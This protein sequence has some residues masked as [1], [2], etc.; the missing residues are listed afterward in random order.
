MSTAALPT[1]PS[2]RALARLVLQ[3]ALPRP[4]KAVLHALL[5][6]ARADLTVYHSQGQLAWECD[7][8]RPIIKKALATLKAQAILRVR[9]GPRQHYATEYRLDLSRL[10]SRA[11]Y[12]S[13][14]STDDDVPR[15]GVGSLG[16]REI[17]LPA[18][19]AFLALQGATQLPPEGATAPAQHENQLPSDNAEGHSVTPSGQM[20]FPQ[21][22]QQEQEKKVFVHTELEMPR[23][24]DAPA[25]DPPPTPI[26]Q[27]P[28]Q[29]ATRPPEISA[30]ADLPLT[31]ALRRWAAETVPGL[32]VERERDKFLCYTRAHGL[33]NADWSEALKGWL[34][35]AHARA[36]RRGDLQSTAAPTPAPELEPQPHYDP[37]LHAQMKVDIAR[38]EQ[39]LGSIGRPICGT[40]YS[41][42]PRRCR[43]PTLGTGEG[44]A[45]EHDPA[46]LA[47][48]EA[49]R[50]VLRAQ[51]EFLHVQAQRLE[52]ASA[53]D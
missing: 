32:H 6:Y 33:H 4:Q 23:P 8:T 21:V 11:S 16:Q 10:P 52:A 36:V 38:L 13:Q 46:Y 3:S 51:G 30:P 27:R 20:G 29:A 31:E 41:Q 26:P 50:A 24:H 5:A 14:A 19:D 53:A 47:R 34:L 44:T 15:N 49:R 17:E 2:F 18:D 1:C 25:D 9:Q 40:R 12:R 48:M 37:E 28:R 45:L 22:V 35:E 7:Y 39:L 43:W 42:R